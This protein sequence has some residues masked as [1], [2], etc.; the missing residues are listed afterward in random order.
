L[1]EISKIEDVK[2]TTVDE[3]QETTQNVAENSF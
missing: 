3:E 2:D 1:E